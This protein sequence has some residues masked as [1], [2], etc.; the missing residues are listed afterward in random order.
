MRGG[1]RVMGGGAGMGVGC[2]VGEALS[3]KGKTGKWQRRETC[4]IIT[5]TS[6]YHA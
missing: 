3:V 1:G 2:E 4:L 5:D 6:R